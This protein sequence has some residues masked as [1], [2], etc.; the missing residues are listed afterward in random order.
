MPTTIQDLRAVSIRPQALLLIVFGL[1]IGPGYFAFS[2]HLSGRSGKSYA[3]TERANRW[4][5]PD[6]SILR[7][8]GGQAYKPVPLEL[9]PDENGYRLRF[10]FNVTETDARD[11]VDNY[12]ATLLQGDIGVVQRSF[13]V[14]GSGKV[15]V[16]LDPLQILYPGSYLLVLE[17]IGKPALA[18]SGVQLRVDTG[19]EKP[20]MWIAWSGLVLIVCGIAI[21]VRDMIVKVRRRH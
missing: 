21:I 8:R 12:Q 4:M 15:D 20:R 13:S 2:H 10:S 17:E 11:A 19:V 3:M 7:L 14:K 16:A 1:L 6:G 5:L 18:V 9:T